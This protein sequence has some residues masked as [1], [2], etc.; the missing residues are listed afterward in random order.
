MSSITGEGTHPVL[1]CTS[2]EGANSIFEDLVI[3]EGLGEVG[4]GMTIQGSQPTITNCTFVGNDANY[5]GGLGIRISASPLVTDCRFEGNSAV[6]RGGGTSSLNGSQPTFTNCTFQGNTAGYWGGGLWSGSDSQTQL[7]DCAFIANTAVNDGGGLVNSDGSNTVLDTCH[8]ESNTSG[9]D[10]GGIANIGQVELSLTGCSFIANESAEDGG[11]LY[12][13]SGTCT[14]SDCDFDGNIAAA[15]GGGTFTLGADLISTFCTFTNNSANTGGAVASADTG[16]TLLGASTICS[17]TLDQIKG[18]WTDLG[19]NCIMELCTQDADADEVVDC[20]DGCPDDPEKTEPG[21]CGCGTPDTDSDQDGTP[22]CTDGCPNDPD[23]TEPGLCGCGTPDTDAD[24]DG[25]P[26]CIDGCPADPE[27]TAPGQCGCGSP[28]TDTDGDGVA[29]CNDDC[30]TWVG[31]CLEDGTLIVTPSESIQ[32]AIDVAPDGGVLAL[33]AG[34]FTPSSTLDLAGRALTIRGSIGGDGA[35]ASIID[36]GGTRRVLIINQGETATTIL[37]SLVL[38]N[39]DA[40]EEEG[41]ALLIED[42]SPTLINCRFIA[43]RALF[44]GAISVRGGQPILTDCWFEA[45]EAQEGGGALYAFGGAPILTNCTLRDNEATVGFG[46]AIL[47]YLGSSIELSGGTVVENRAG[48][49]GGGLYATNSSQLT[50]TSTI[51]CGNTPDQIVGPLETDDATCIQTT[52]FDCDLIACPAD[53]DGDGV[54]D[55]ADL[56][57]LLA[58]W[59]CSGDDCPA[60]LNT[61][62]TVNGAD[63]TIILSAWGDC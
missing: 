62:G 51:V 26:D 50:L 15:R 40:D 24:Q 44:G 43:N 42:T 5:G 52:C 36:G 16:S 9:N 12:N 6:Y 11:G 21:L 39:G 41:G 7:T 1:V 35:P 13:D 55:G 8:F 49:T 20:E 28:D 47:G 29:D 33:T 57:L 18:N 25:T 37:E 31:D 46:G 59:G 61:D 45:N 63:L 53:L 27:K 38:Q 2:G 23:K 34:T 14:L 54:V 3:T 48:A 30:P 32:H 4:G 19:E 58:D 22:D 60:D 10:G 56:T 17:N